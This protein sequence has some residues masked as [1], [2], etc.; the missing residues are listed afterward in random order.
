CLLP[1][2]IDRSRVDVEGP[3]YVD[4]EHRLAVLRKH[5]VEHLVAQDAGGIEHDVEPAE[6]IA[7]LLHHGEAIVELG[8]RAVIGDRLAARL[9]DLVDDLLRWR[10]IAA[11]AA[12]ADARAVDHDLGAL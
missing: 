6:G 9:L 8:D 7:R 4:V 5:V 12:T 10:L 2:E 11:L 3:G 1:E